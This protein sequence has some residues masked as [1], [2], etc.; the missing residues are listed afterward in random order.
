MSSIS[1]SPNYLPS[2]APD[3]LPGGRE[4]ARCPVELFESEQV[5]EKLP[6][7]ISAILLVAFCGVFWVGTITLGRWALDAV[8]LLF[9]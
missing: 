4:L 5:P 6:I 1:H 8:A 7:W 9:T 3:V 2:A